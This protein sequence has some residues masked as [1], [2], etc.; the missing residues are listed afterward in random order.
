MEKLYV[1]PGWKFKDVKENIE[2][3]KAHYLGVLTSFSYF[4]KRERLLFIK[5]SKKLIMSL[6]NILDWQKDRTWEAIND[7]FDIEEFKRLN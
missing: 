2:A 1:N 7:D 6:N 3:L 5:E 4:E